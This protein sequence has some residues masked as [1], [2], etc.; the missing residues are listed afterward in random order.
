MKTRSAFA[1]L[2]VGLAA[3]GL[4]WGGFLD[5]A[6]GAEKHKSPAPPAATEK[7]QQYPYIGVGVAPVS[8]ALISHLPK[9]FSHGQGLLVASVAVGSPA[10]KAEL[11]VHDIL[12]TYGDQELFSPRQLQGL[13][14]QD[15]VG[16]EVALGIVREGKRLTVK[17][18]L[19][20]P[21]TSSAAPSEIPDTE[22]WEMPM[23]HGLIPGWRLPHRFVVG[24][25]PGPSQARKWDSF[26]SMTVKKLGKD[27]FHV[28][29]QYLNTK[30]GT[31]H[32]AFE[33]SCEEIHKDILAQKDLPAVERH[34]LL[35][36]LDLPMDQA[37][38]PVAQIES[39]L[40]EMWDRTFPDWAI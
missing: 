24:P 4:S 11:K 36:S 38:S 33:G 5:A 35:R 10:E 26:D 8:P 2:A 7:P 12:M 6:R 29:I 1:A 9:V 30:G 3:F 37:G 39:D 22:F 19:G 23:P 31:D 14:R 40:K 32:K 34:Q 15:K 28:E 16:H 25:T 18:T 13:V 27:R 20:A 21:E 17:V